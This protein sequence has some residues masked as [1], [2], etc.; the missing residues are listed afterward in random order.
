MTLKSVIMSKV[1]YTTPS[2][3]TT[4]MGRMK[5]MKNIRYIFKNWDRTNIARRMYIYRSTL[6]TRGRLA[7]R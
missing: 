6:K 1:S 2:V 7:T 3:F 4:R 5:T